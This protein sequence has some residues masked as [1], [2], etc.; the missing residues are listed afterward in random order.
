VSISL[1]AYGFAILS[2]VC[3]QSFFSIGQLTT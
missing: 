2:E 3:T 1:P